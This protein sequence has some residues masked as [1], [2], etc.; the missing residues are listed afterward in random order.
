MCGPARSGIIRVMFGA[1]TVD[2]LP[3][4]VITFSGYTSLCT[5]G[6]GSVGSG[7]HEGLFDFDTRILSRYRFRI[8]GE[9]PSFVSGGHLDASRWAGSLRVPIPGGTPDG[10]RLPRDTIEVA[11]QRRV[12]NGLLDE[13]E[14]VNHSMLP[15]EVRL[16]LDL[17]ADFRELLARANDRREIGRVAAAWHAS[18]AALEFRFTAAHEE[19]HAERGTRVRVLDA[20]ALERTPDGLAVRLALPP[21]GR[22]ALV[23]VVESLVDGR[24]R[25]PLTLAPRVLDPTDRDRAREAWDAERPHLEP[26]ATPIAGAFETAA[27]DFFALRAW[28]R[29]DPPDPAGGWTVAAGVPEYAGVFGRDVLTAGWQA[30]LL[31]AAPMRGA[32]TLIDRTQARVDDPFRDAE[33]GKML[34]EMRRG[35][36]S[37][38]AIVPQRAYYGS[39]TTPAMFVLTLS[40]LWHW[41]GDLEAVRRHRDAAIRAL[42]WARDR[43]DLDGDGFLEYVRRAPVGPKNQGWKDSDDAIRSAD[44][45]QVKN[46]IA[47]VEEQAFHFLALQRMAELLVA[48][49]E[50][51]LAAT[52]LERAAVLKRRWDEA[53]WMPDEGFY[54][55]GLDPDK[56]QIRSIGSNAGHALGTGIVP[57][58]RAPD[59]IRRLFQPDLF[60]GWGIRTLSSAHP[61]YNPCAYHLGTVWP[62]EQA[63]FALGMK[64][65]GFDA[66][67]E[68]LVTA[69]LQAASHFRDA[70]LPEAIGGHGSEERRLPV[71]Y[72]SA[73]V[74][75]AWSASAVIQFVQILLGLYPFAP[76]AMIALIRPRLPEWLPTLTVRNVRVGDAR[77][78][79]RFERAADG[80]AHHTVLERSGR[81]LVVTAPPPSGATP[82]GFAE[83]AKRWVIEHAPGPQ[84]RALRI[85]LGVED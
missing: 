43:G 74:P 55:M 58:E 82:E 69:Q 9:Q 27:T 12:G 53:F 37:E 11:I 31:D 83:S 15:A 20:P 61:S 6:D 67:A 81:L 5:G 32:L 2:P 71:A 8:D 18:T 25:S 22:A 36:L 46:P 79:L 39:Q 33:P 45:R 10:P 49:A 85:A 47:T 17:E 44:G 1:G 84:M 48:L 57:A 19:H 72:P 51:E 78:S 16:T 54:A 76:L 28:D 65:Y 40:E 41:T 3:G 64:R 52:Y 21:K 34:H 23:V 30:A 26:A 73:N 80:N 35:P 70:R 77:I 56:R 66:D 60:S 50:D 75:Q 63:T 42:D 68:R 24:W 14:V 38:T 13:L 4:R 59:V 62:V 29:G 7:D